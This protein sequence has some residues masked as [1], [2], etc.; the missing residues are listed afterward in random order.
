MVMREPLSLSAFLALGILFLSVPSPTAAGSG[1]GLAVGGLSENPRALWVVRDALIS[2]ARIHRMV[3]EAYYSGVTDLLIQVR[4]RGDAYYLS[5]LVPT[6]PALERAWSR[7]GHFDPLALV[8]EEARSRGLRVHAW[9]NVYLV[10]GK[11]DSPPGHLIHTHPEWVSVD[12]RGVS[13]LDIP[14]RHLLKVGDEGVFL[15]PGNRRVVRHF[16]ASL[17]S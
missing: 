17:T 16:P 9:L 3:E 13:M 15:E 7:R 8:I 6:A 14:Y 5:S 10:K 1:D 11:A 12:S 4:G 2:P